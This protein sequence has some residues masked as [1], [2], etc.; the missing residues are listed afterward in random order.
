MSHKISILFPL[1]GLSCAQ[2]FN[3]GMFPIHQGA[4]TS[5]EQGR[6]ADG[7]AAYDP[8]AQQE[9][10]KKSAKQEIYESDFMKAVLSREVR[11]ICRLVKHSRVH[12]LRSIRSIIDALYYIL[13]EPH[14]NDNATAASVL[15]DRFVKEKDFRSQEFSEGN[16]NMY[17]YVDKYNQLLKLAI[18]KNYEKIVKKLIKN[19]KHQ[20]DPVAIINYTQRRGGEPLLHYLIKLTNQKTKK[21]VEMLLD[22]PGIKLD[23]Q[24]NSGC[25]PLHEAIKIYNQAIVTLLLAKGA[26]VDLQDNFGYTPLHDA[27][28][29][30]NQ[31][32]VTLLLAK[33]ATVD[34]QDNSGCTPLHKASKY[35]NDAVVG[36]LLDEGASVDVEDNLGSTPLHEASQLCNYGV[37]QL[38]LAK[39]AKVNVKDDSGSTPLNCALTA[40]SVESSDKEKV[41]KLLTDYLSFYTGKQTSGEVLASRFKLSC[42]R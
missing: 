10:R 28:K 32:V 26:T 12:K 37:V 39:G 35:S 11:Q 38:L 19:I 27:C 23:L 36:L 14:S 34:L 7:A 9:P 22:V 6:Q 8:V 41:I 1:L 3:H 24:D 42:F 33:G 16:G 40:Q 4:S 15:V 18:E 21:W 31:V 29:C 30:S 17:N 25:T 2:Q 5:Q 20:D 13:R